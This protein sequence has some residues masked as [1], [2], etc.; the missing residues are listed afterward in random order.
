MGRLD[1]ELT[2]YFSQSNP[3]IAKKLSVAQ[4]Y[5][6]FEKAVKYVWRENEWAAHFV[7]AHVNAFYVTKEDK[8]VRKKYRDSTWIIGT[9]CV[10][11]GMVRADLD[12]RQEL[13]KLALMS[14]GIHFDELRLLPSKFDMKKRHPFQA[15]IDLLNGGLLDAGED[16]RSE[17]AP[18]PISQETLERAVA[19]V[20]DP[21]LAR[22]LGKAMVTTAA[23]AH[24]AATGT[25]EGFALEHNAYRLSEEQENLETLK[26]AL[27]LTLG[28]HTDQVL[29]KI[30]RIYLEPQLFDPRRRNRRE[31]QTYNCYIYSSDPR[32]STIVEGFGDTVRS[33]AGR[34]GLRI[35]AFSVRPSTA[36]ML[37]DRAYP[38]DSAPMTWRSGESGGS[39]AVD[40]DA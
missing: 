5:A 2:H 3:E 20:D 10:D 39:L 31:F 23:W 29:D 4:N 7:L 14:E 15:S 35:G 6:A 28:E 40:A 37:N 32:L 19:A 16:R 1:V 33:R 30:N 24:E 36:E 18:E 38:K 27:I 26:R 8:P 12:A 11:D 13:L 17:E 21:E 34:L 25:K 9:I 22:R